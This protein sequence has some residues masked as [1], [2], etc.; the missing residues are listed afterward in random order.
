MFW[1]HTQP[2]PAHLPHILWQRDLI[3]DQGGV[4]G[5]GSHSC[6]QALPVSEDEDRKGQMMGGLH[7]IVIQIL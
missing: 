6:A 4:S 2:S 1:G 3:L 5:L 7:G